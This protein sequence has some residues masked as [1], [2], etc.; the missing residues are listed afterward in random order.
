MK[1]QSS[2]FLH[3]GEKDKMV[4]RNIGTDTLTHTH[5]HTHTQRKDKM[6]QQI[7][8]SKVEKGT[9]W[10]DEVGIDGFDLDCCCCCCCWSCWSVM[11]ISIKMA[12]LRCSHICIGRPRYIED[13]FE[14]VSEYSMS[15]TGLFMYAPSYTY[16]A[17]YANSAKRHVDVDGS[18]RWSIR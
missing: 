12:S 18:S 7:K 8:I 14:V 4:N 11:L 3:R 13:H 16:S 5:T 15:W 1:L 17:A 10:I 9:D 2:I 6:K